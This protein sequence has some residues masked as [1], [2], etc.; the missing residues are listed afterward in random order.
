MEQNGEGVVRLY[1]WD[2]HIVH[3]H[4]ANYKASVVASSLGV[5][6]GYAL[7]RFVLPFVAVDL[8]EW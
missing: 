3:P 7:R 2:P 5:G 8:C 4:D 1:A 6:V